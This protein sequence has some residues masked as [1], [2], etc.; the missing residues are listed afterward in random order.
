MTTEEERRRAAAER[1]RG[2]L[3]RLESRPSDEGFWRALKV[4]GSFGWPIALMSLL[5]VAAGRAI[6]GPRWATATLIAVGAGIGL[7]AALSGVG[8]RG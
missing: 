2:D 3:E 6:G 1:T 5:G 8:R 4:L 7:A